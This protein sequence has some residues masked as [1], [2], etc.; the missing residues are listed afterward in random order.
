[1]QTPAM[2]KTVREAFDIVRNVVFQP[3]DSVDRNAFA[4]AGPDAM[5]AYAGDMIVLQDGDGYEFILL[6]ADD[7]PSP[8]PE[9][10]TFG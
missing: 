8:E 7:S 5:I 6:P 1:M 9:T 4:G 3:L 10:I 2:P